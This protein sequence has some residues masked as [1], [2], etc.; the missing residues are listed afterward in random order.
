MSL[1]RHAHAFLTAVG[2]LTRIPVAGET[3]RPG[4]APAPLRD[5]V[6]YFPAVGAL[7]GLATGSVIACALYFWPPAVAVVLGLAFEAVLTGGLHEDAVADFCDAFGGGWTREDI[8]RILKDSRIGSFGA[9]GLGLAVLLR[10]A[11][12]AALPPADLLAATVAAA[13]WGRFMILPVMARVPPVSDRPGSARDFGEGVRAREV[14]L[15]LL[16]ALAAI[17]PFLAG[18]P[19]NAAIAFIASGL[20]LAWFVSYLRRRLGGVTGDC[21]GAACYAGQLLVLLAASSRMT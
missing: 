15:G 2:L 1:N 5:A 12:T 3:V 14:G 8:L 6:A 9:L 19:W 18:R 21:L 7:I 11:A 13:T 10:A 4:E 17:S 16:W 20:F